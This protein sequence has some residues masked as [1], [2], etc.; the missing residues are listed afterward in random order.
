MIDDKRIALPD[1][2]KV[3]QRQIIGHT[4]PHGAALA[5]KIIVGV[6]RRVGFQQPAIGHNFGSQESEV[7]SQN[8]EKHCQNDEGPREP[9]LAFNSAFWLLT[10]DFSIS[11][12]RSL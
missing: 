2:A 3:L 11:S 1:F 7:R 12:E 6:I 4:I 5:L 8:Q 10:P 9:H